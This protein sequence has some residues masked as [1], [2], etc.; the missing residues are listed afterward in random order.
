MVRV[1]KLPEV[2]GN[3]LQGRNA[4]L[5]LYVTMMWSFSGVV[6]ETSFCYLKGQQMKL[7]SV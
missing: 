5:P 1:V 2:S 6:E 4:S 7:S 3:G